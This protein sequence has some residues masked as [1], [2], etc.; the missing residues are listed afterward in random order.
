MKK[1]EK[2]RASKP[3]QNFNALEQNLCRWNNCPDPVTPSLSIA[4]ISAIS[5]QGN[6]RNDFLSLVYLK[7][8]HGYV[9]T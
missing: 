1:C 9:E 3:L 4:K 6:V 8:M 7:H 2:C 5:D